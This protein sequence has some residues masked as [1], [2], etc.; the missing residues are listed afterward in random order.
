MEDAAVGPPEGEEYQRRRDAFMSKTAAMV[1]DMHFHGLSHAA[2]D[3]YYK[4]ML[5]NAEEV[6]QLQKC[7]GEAKIKKLPRHTTTIRR[8]LAKKVL[9]PV[10]TTTYKKVWQKKRNGVVVSYREEEVGTDEVMPKKTKGATRWHHRVPLKDLK[11][12][13]EC[14]HGK[15]V[16]KKNCLRLDVSIDGLPVNAGRNQTG[17][18]KMKAV[19]FIWPCCGHPYITA[20]HHSHKGREPDAEDLLRPIMDEL[21]EADIKIR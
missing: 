13:V 10:L 21:Q 16:G 19:S 15:Q 8:Q 7:A 14:V 9:P 6:S 11:T 18:K 5:D 17:N 2:I 1:T 4:F 3:K 20:I 12:F